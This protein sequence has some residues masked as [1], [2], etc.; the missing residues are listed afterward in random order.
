VVKVLILCTRKCRNLGHDIKILAIPYFRN[1]TL[2]AKVDE[3]FFA[4]FDQADV[5]YPCGVKEPYT[6]CE[7]L[8]YN[9]DYVF[10]QNPYDTVFDNSVVSNFTNRK[11]RDLGAKIMYIVYGPHIFHQHQV[12]D[13]NLPNLVDVIFVD[14]QSTTEIYSKYFNFAKKNIIVAGYATYKEIR[15]NIHQS[16]KKKNMETILWLPRWQLTFKL[17]NEGESGSTFLNYYHFFYNYAKDNPHIH[18]IVRPHM[19]LMVN[20]LESMYL[21]KDDFDNIFAKFRQ[22]SNVTV[23]GHAN[24]PLENDILRS[25]IV[26]ADGTSSLAEAVVADKPIIYLS[27]GYNLEFDTN[28]LGKNLKQYV[29][30]AYDPQDIVNNLNFIRSTNY[31]AFYDRYLIAPNSPKWKI[32]AKKYWHS[33]KKKFYAEFT[34]IVVQ[35]MSLKKCLIQ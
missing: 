33:I 12:D 15:D 16:T 6:I 3:E 13:P 29:Y 18:L 9:P 31:A 35:G 26:I 17:R 11:F 8:N 34:H 10:T 27:N 24:V 22:L 20:A 5:I 2:V 1:G 19:F 7:S 23:S 21:S 25:D 32:L 4:K 14:S 30:F 28:Q